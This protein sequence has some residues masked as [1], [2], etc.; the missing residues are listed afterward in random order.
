MIKYVTYMIENP[1]YKWVAIFP[2][3]V[4]G[5]ALATA[6]S[7]CIGGIIPLIYFAKDNSSSLKLTKAKFNAK[8]VIAACVN[9]SSELLPILQCLLSV[10][11]IMAI[12]QIR[13]RRRC[14]SIRCF[15]VC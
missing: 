11:S 12:A 8:T 9:G 1:Y 7:Q 10:C 3:G 15:D 6:S 2:L 13:R 4:I 14:C 5:A